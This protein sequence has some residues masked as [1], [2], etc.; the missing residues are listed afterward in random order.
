MRILR[1]Y[2]KPCETRTYTPDQTT[3]IFQTKRMLRMIQSNRSSSISRSNSMRTMGQK[4]HISANIIANKITSQINRF[5][6]D[7]ISRT[8]YRNSYSEKLTFRVL[9]TYNA[10]N[11]NNFTNVF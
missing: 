7:F 4:K 11:D 2:V 1:M 10:I 3:K 5:E 6:S 8:M 9:T